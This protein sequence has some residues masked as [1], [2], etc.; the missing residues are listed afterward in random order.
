MADIALCLNLQGNFV[1]ARDMLL[2]TLNVLRRCAATADTQATA[3][4]SHSNLAVR[5]AHLS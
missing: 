3:A 1:D 4:L 5:R 2:E